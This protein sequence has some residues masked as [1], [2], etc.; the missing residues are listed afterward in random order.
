MVFGNERTIVD[1]CPDIGVAPDKAGR[2]LIR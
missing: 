2:G 1:G